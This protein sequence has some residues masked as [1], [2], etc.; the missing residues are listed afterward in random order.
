M[1]I[2]ARQQAGLTLVSTSD[3]SVSY[4]L[5]HMTQRT[6]LWLVSQHSKLNR[7]EE[8]EPILNDEGKPTA[9]VDQFELGWELMRLSLDS[10]HGLED[11]DENGK[12]IEW[13]PEFV[14][15]QIMG[16]PMLLITT[17]SLDLIPDEILNE[18]ML[19]VSNPSTGLSVGDLTGEEKKQVNFTRSSR[20]KK[21]SA[22]VPAT[23]KTARSA[24]AAKSKS[25]RKKTKR[26]TKS[27]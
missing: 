16:K 6:K 9:I 4:T 14:S 13:K 3:K 15:E 25:V 20:R 7:D 27:R 26:A 24:P 8:G 1:K 23:R 22:N 19:I 17:D 5:R 18:I 21:S 11:E 10:I 12:P 2:K